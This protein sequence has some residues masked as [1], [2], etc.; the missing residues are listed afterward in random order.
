MTDAVPSGVT[1]E[2][3]SQDVLTSYPHIPFTQVC[4]DQLHAIT[5]NHAIRGCTSDLRK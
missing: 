1:K 2:D 5:V 3:T 4:V